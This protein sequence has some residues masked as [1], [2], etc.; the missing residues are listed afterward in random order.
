MTFPLIL[1]K[2]TLLLA[3]HGAVAAAAAASENLFSLLEIIGLWW[4]LKW[5]NIG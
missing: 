2:M 3:I 4:W 1:I 5:Q